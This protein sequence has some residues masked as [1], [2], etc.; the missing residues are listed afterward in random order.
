MIFEYFTLAKVLCF[1]GLFDVRRFV[2]SKFSRL[3]NK[4][5]VCVFCVQHQQF[6]TNLFGFSVWLF[7]MGSKPL[8]D[9]LNTGFTITENGLFSGG[10]HRE[11]KL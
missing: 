4:F 1:G 10:E 2:M 5:E 8:P 7:E 11:R 3:S 6:A 9:L